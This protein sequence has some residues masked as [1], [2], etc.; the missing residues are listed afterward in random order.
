VG[1]RNEVNGLRQVLDEYVIRPG[2]RVIAH[3]L[4]WTTATLLIG[5]GTYAILMFQQDE[6]YIQEWKAKRSAPVT[7]AA[8][9]PPAPAL[10]ISAR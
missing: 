7:T 9:A 8:S 5:I 3:T 1:V 10:S 2:R 6:A 4:I